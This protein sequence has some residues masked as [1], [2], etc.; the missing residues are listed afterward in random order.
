[1]TGPRGDGG[2]GRVAIVGAG[3]IGTALGLALSASGEVHEVGL[4][5]RDRGVAAR[6]LERGAGDRALPSVNEA[7]AADVVILAVPVPAIL[8]LVRELGPRLRTGSVLLDTGS[9]KSAVVQTM[10]ARVPREVHAVGGHPLAGTERPGPEGADPATLPGSPFVLTP[11][12]RDPPAVAAAAAVVRAVGAVPLVMEAEEHDRI[13]ARTSHLSHLAAFA[14]RAV[15]ERTTGTAALEGPGFA[16]ATRL[17]RSSPDM[18]AGFLAANVAEVRAAA[19][20]FRESLDA[21]VAALDEGPDR[22]A[23]ALRPAEVTT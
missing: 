15:A 18:V 22:L 19:A 2:L 5:D 9:A 17:A 20:E 14:L 4:F 23:A 13:V 21:L 8:D 6:S 11:V 7:C 16:S 12:R 10:R 1:M 3:Q